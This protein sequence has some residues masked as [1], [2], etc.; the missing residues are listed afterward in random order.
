MRWPPP[1]RCRPTD[2][3]VGTGDFPYLSRIVSQSFDFDLDR[4]FEFGL[5]RLLDGFAALVEPS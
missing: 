4:L 5:A 1:N 2:A 3:I